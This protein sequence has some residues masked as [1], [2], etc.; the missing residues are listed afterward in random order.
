MV[1]APEWK[2]TAGAGPASEKQGGD[3]GRTLRKVRLWLRN[4]PER[5]SPAVAEG[6]LQTSR[7]DGWLFTW[8]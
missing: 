6:Q 5:R 4:T 1:G 2:C 8:V 7:A 3:G